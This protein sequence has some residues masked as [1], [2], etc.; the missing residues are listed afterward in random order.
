M[1]LINYIYF[2]DSSNLKDFEFFFI[3]KTILN[4]FIDAF[5]YEKIWSKREA[6]WNNRSLKNELMQALCVEPVKNSFYFEA[7]EFSLD[8][9]HLGQAISKILHTSNHFFYYTS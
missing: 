7:H 4:F 2:V 9:S 1:P 8:M 5:S 6:Y 3:S